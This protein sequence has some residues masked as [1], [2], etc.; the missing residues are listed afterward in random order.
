MNNV[1]IAAASVEI[2]EPCGACGYVGEGRLW[3]VFDHEYD[4]PFRAKYRECVKC[5]TL[6]QT[7]MPS[8]TQLAAFYPSDY[9]SFSPTDRLMKA[10]ISMRVNRLKKVL[11]GIPGVILDYGCGNGAFLLEAARQLPDRQFFGYE[12]DNENAVVQHLDGRVQIFRGDASAMFETMQSVAVACINHVIEHLP[13]PSDVIRQIAAKLAPAG[14]IDGQTPRADSLERNIFGECWAGFH[15]PRHT[16]IFSRAGIERIFKRNGF[17]S[18]RVNSAFN[19][20]GIAI[21]LGSAL[22]GFRSGSI[23]RSGLRWLALVGVAT[24][25]T[26]I[27]LLSG[28]SGIMDF[29]ARRN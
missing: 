18:I 28:R 8:L 1:T 21:S 6:T 12:I 19:P 25:L 11:N 22:Q 9:H 3:P 14:A 23:R 17:N 5:G 15:A 13:D 16:V 26:P 20:G 2:L 4:R 29:T 7:P 24:A 10:R 27:D